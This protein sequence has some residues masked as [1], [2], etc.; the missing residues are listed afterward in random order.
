MTGRLKDDVGRYGSASFSAVS[1]AS[2]RLCVAIGSEFAGGDASPNSLVD[3]W[4]GARWLEQPAAAPYNVDV[5]DVGCSAL[6]SCTI[7]GASTPNI[8]PSAYS[9]FAEGWDGS[10]WSVE[11]TA[12][13]QV[14]PPSA[15]Q[16]DFLAGASCVASTCIAVGWASDA[17]GLEK[18]VIEQYP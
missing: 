15:S 17:Y 13:P 5:R 3:R 11:P 14:G 4:D 9:T 7:V 18:T 10:S 1:C 12:N 16:P 2:R 6:L 8:V